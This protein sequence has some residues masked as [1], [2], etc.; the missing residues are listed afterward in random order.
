MRKILFLFSFFLFSGL[1]TAQNKNS[2]KFFDKLSSLCGKS[3]EGEVVS[4]AKEGDGFT[5]K[6]LVMQVLSCEDDRLRIPF[7][8]ED[9]QSRTWV[10]IKDQSGRLEL[11]HDHRIEDG[12][13]DKITQYGGKSTNYGFENQQI[14]PADLQTA[15][16]IGYASGNIWWLGLD[17]KSFTY[18]LRRIGQ[19]R[20]FSVRFDLTNPIEFNERP[21]GWK[22]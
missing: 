3:F 13:E 17:E 9:N 7:Y 15:D 14:F 21:W 20:L 4:G 16:L 8:V 6:K 11:R 10:I 22:D 19:D 5:G 2:E 1:F 18:N 12:S